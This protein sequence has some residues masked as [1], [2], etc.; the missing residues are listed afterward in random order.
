MFHN[1]LFVV[2]AYEFDVW[3]DTIWILSTCAILGAMWM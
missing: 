3:R 2:F 1:V